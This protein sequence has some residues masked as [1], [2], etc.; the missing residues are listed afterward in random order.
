MSETFAPLRSFR[1]T[2]HI[3]REDKIGYSFFSGIKN[4][5]RRSGNERR[6]TGLEGFDNPF[7]SVFILPHIDLKINNYDKT[8]TFYTDF[9][10]ICNLFVTIL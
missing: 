5:R 10:T 6:R 4:T 1:F 9:V 8:V 3:M 7:L 2:V